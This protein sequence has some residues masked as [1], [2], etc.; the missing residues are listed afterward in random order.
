MNIRDI[1]KRITH[2]LNV[3]Y[4]SLD[5][6][7]FWSVAGLILFGMILT[8]SASPAV[9]TR[10]KAADSFHFIKKQIIFLI[11]AIGLMLGV[12]MLP[13]RWIKRLSL[14]GLTGALVLCVVVLFCGDSIKGGTRW[15]SLFG[16]NVQPSE[17]LK[18]CFAV[19]C[20][21]FFEKGLLDADCPGIKIA[22]GL[23]GVSALLVFLQHDV[24][25]TTTIALMWGCQLFLAGLSLK[26][27]A[28]II[29][30]ACSLAG[31]VYC[32]VPHFR[33]RVD[34][35]LF[36]DKS[37]VFQVKTALEAFHHGGWFGRGP[38]EGIIQLKIPDAHTDFILAVAAEEYGFLISAGLILLFFFI[39]IRGLSLMLNEK[40]LFVML[41]IAG[42]LTQ[43]GV[44]ACI[45][46]ASTLHLMPTKGMT[47][48]FISYGG[49]SLVSFGFAFGI[50]LALT[51]RERTL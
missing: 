42:L 23:L 33:K 22:W 15:I 4:H 50:I 5:K 38:G 51:R 29:A 14:L 11:P 16:V 26:W 40:N 49:S 21:V 20:A 19:V 30:C 18:P 3:W 24:G 6:C 28:P 7:L 34:G 47:L 44:Q 10:I 39:L 36:P 13:I 25:M 31:L 2:F 41:A 12:S 27:L 45:N 9:A 35:F 17:F 37:D 32:I 8:F 48:P 1:F 43:F 46:M